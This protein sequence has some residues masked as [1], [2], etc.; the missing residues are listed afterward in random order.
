[1]NSQEEQTTD[2]GEIPTN[3]ETTPVTETDT[4]SARV[5]TPNTPSGNFTGFVPPG[6][7]TPIGQ[8]LPIAQSPISV[9]Q[10][11][12]LEHSTNQSQLSVQNANLTRQVNEL[13]RTN[14]AMM[15]QF[16]N[17]GQPIRR[18]LF[19]STGNAGN[20]PV[21]V[22]LGQGIPGHII[23][24]HQ[25][26]PVQYRLPIQSAP[27]NQR[28]PL[29][30]LPIPGIDMIPRNPMYH[31]NQ[32]PPG[33][34]GA[35]SASQNDGTNRQ[36]ASV[37][38]NPIAGHIDPIG[39]S[40]HQQHPPIHSV[41]YR[42]DTAR[43]TND[44]AQTQ[45]RN[46]IPPSTSHYPTNWANWNQPQQ[47]N[48]DQQQ[49]TW[50]GAYSH[51]ESREYVTHSWKRMLEHEIMVSQDYDISAFLIC[52]DEVTIGV[53]Y[54]GTPNNVLALKRVLNS[55]P[56]LIAHTG[57]LHKKLATDISDG[58]LIA[59][60]F[61]VRLLHG[62]IV[63][64][65][66]LLEYLG[67][68]TWSNI[69]FNL[70]LE[71]GLTSE[72]RTEIRPSKRRQT[73]GET[74]KQHVGRTPIPTE[75]D[76]D[77]EPEE[78]AISQSEYHGFSGGFPSHNQ[79]GY[80]H[81]GKPPF[82]NVH[83]HHT[84]YQR[85]GDDK[86]AIRIAQDKMKTLNT[87]ATSMQ[88]FVAYAGTTNER[89]LDKKLTQY[90]DFNN[91]VTTMLQ[92][93][94]TQTLMKA[95]VIDI[96]DIYLLVKDNMTTGYL[97]TVLDDLYRESKVGNVTY[98][99][100]WETVIQSEQAFMKFVA[101]KVFKR[102]ELNSMTGDIF[103]I[104]QGG[105]SVSYLHKKIHIYL[106]AGCTLAEVF[107][108][109]P[110]TP[111]NAAAAFLK[112]VDSKVSRK[113]NKMMEELGYTTTTVG[114]FTWLKLESELIEN[115]VYPEGFRPK[116]SNPNFKAPFRPKLNS[117]EEVG[118][119][120][121]VGETNNSPIE[122]DTDSD[123]SDT[124]S[125]TEEHLNFIG[126]NNRNRQQRK[127]DYKKKTYYK[128]RVN[129]LEQQISQLVNSMTP[130]ASNNPSLKP[131]EITEELRF[132]WFE[133]RQCVNC[134]SPTHKLAQC[135]KPKD[136][137]ALKELFEKVKLRQVNVLA[138]AFDSIPLDPQQAEDD[139]SQHF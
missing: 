128:E 105:L 132:K 123:E 23:S 78:D 5:G 63:S 24:S 109:P 86:N 48:T 106:T 87:I 93:A 31:T 27:T 131:T 29:Q 81:H 36:R 33:F 119:E 9:V 133:G 1:M 62:K 39:H 19:Q 96:S 114:L 134:G 2:Q 137:T 138:A 65:Q 111:A 46:E 75:K 108:V 34:P 60:E 102:K 117:L 40:V 58:H 12:S 89:Y 70:P 76:S 99:H 10:N 80:G 59:R 72:F 90:H 66:D 125:E 22:P 11:N 91:N 67:E 35:I 51:P 124:D 74:D 73:I 4:S 68:N 107:Q 21:R 79:Y 41:Q 32:A 28:Q 57:K 8:Q 84:G 92:T 88:K 77:D 110:I 56:S 14:A 71:G 20:V 130:N 17:I 129:A 115:Q 45:F 113:I 18:P 38:T 55:I 116:G 101:H 30:T 49:Y 54:I 118:Q 6:N 64:Y 53:Y 122:I 126:K 104:N 112:A 3:Q 94:T 25:Q 100:T 121:G 43:H 85:G 16:Q 82:P 47:Y 139:P 103:S 44:T 15:E 50:N 26:M 83:H 42:P 98:N 69:S 95:E 136:Q 97:K 37:P 120:G 127:P 135:L 52:N 7:I 13:T 61:P